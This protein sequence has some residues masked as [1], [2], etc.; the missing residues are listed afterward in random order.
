MRDCHTACTGYHPS[1][2]SQSRRRAKRSVLGQ[3]V[4]V[5]GDCMC[6]LKVQVVGRRSNRKELEFEQEIERRGEPKQTNLAI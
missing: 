5:A 2:I 1:A 6:I 4:I 3:C